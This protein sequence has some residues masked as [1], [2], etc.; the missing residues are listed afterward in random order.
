MALG[1][2]FTNPNYTGVLVRLTPARGPFISAIGA[3]AQEL[4]P[5]GYP[6]V[7]GFD[8]T[9]S[10][11]DS[12]Q[13]EDLIAAA[14][15]GAV[16]GAAFAGAQAA[17]ANVFN[18]KQ[19]YQYAVELSWRKQSNGGTVDSGASAAGQRNPVTMTGEIARKLGQIKTDYNYSAVNGTF[20]NPADNTTATK[21]RGILTACSTNVTAKSG[22]PLLQKDDVLQLVQDVYDA[23]GLL[24]PQR[25]MF[26]CGFFQK[27][28]IGELFGYAPQ[29]RN[30]GGVAVDVIE[31]DAGPIG[32]ML[33]G[34]VP[35][36]VLG[37]VSAYEVRPT[38]SLVVRRGK[39]LGVLVETEIETGGSSDMNGLYF[40]AGIRYGAESHHG[41]ITGLGDGT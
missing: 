30:V 1:T 22:S 2:T 14:Q 39:T 19:I 35:S 18:V 24:D 4:G 20:A 13:T 17:R 12:W 11:I 10:K 8:I 16:E 27:R 41:K 9:P 23:G 34:H 29:S 31:T 38:A 6:M 3:Y 5:D 36:T 32:V 33:D 40:D 37:L 15:N 21:T 7:D 26:I 25:S 28:R